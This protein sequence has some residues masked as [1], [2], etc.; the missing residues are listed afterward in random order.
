[1]HTYSQS[2]QAHTHTHA[3]ARICARIPTH[4]LL[5]SYIARVIT[6]TDT[7]TW[8]APESANTRMHTYTHAEEHTC[9]HARRNTHAHKHTCCC[10]HVSYVSTHT[11]KNTHTQKQQ[12]WRA[13]VSADSSTRH[14]V[15]ID[16]ITHTYNTARTC[17]HTRKSTYTHACI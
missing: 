8:R 1:M 2:T 11:H 15:Y 4:L 10:I 13:C 9:V 6:H 17:T 7:Q 3:Y 12:V 16:T 14:L 5:H